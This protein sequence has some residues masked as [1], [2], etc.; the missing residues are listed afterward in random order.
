[1]EF[2]KRQKFLFEEEVKNG[3]CPDDGIRF[4][5]FS[6]RWMEEYGKKNLAVKT[7][8][9]YEGFLVRINQAIGHIKLRDLKPLQLNAFYR[10]LGEDGVNQ[11]TKGKLAPKTILEHHRLISKILNTAIKWQLLE[12]N[13]A[14][15]ADPPKV[16]HKERAYLDDVQTKQMLSLLENE[17]MQYKTM[18]SFLVYTGLRRG[19]LCGLEWKDINFDN[20]MLRVVRSSQ[21]I[22]NQTMQTKEPKTKSGI[23]EFTLNPSACRLLRDYKEWQNEQKNKVGDKWNETDRLFTTW[24]GKP[25][26][27]DTITDWFS[28][29]IKRSG[30][31][32]VTL[33]SLRHTN[34][35][36]MIAVGTDVCTVSKR[37]GH[38]DV[39]TTLNIYSHALKSKDTEAAEKLESA[40]RIAV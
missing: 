19:E 1:M 38:A 16:P 32:Y 2:L 33:H 18:I 40:F 17:P 7:Y 35:T 6:K 5:D 15:R 4:Y 14:M 27:P 11:K 31:P 22:G 37:L 9:R 20:G 13:V 28:K 23:R 36:L 12:T 8:T 25:I 39:S 21:Y 26:H 29:F 24:D 10:N 30:L 34:A 3:I